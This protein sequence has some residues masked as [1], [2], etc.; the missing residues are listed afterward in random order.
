MFGHA[1]LVEL[2]DDAAV[3]VTVVLVAVVL[4]A[5][6]TAAV[7]GLVAASAIIAAPPAAT[8]VAI[9]VASAIARVIC[10]ETRELL[11]VDKSC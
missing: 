5:V 7:A 6:G 11:W 3:P 8:P 9:R 10:S 1:V 2:A 4:V